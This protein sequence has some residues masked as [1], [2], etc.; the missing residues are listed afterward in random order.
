[1]RFEEF[2]SIVRQTVK[3][4]P[5]EFKS[6]LDNVDIVIEIWP[7]YA[8]AKSVFAHPGS[9]LF[10]LYRGVPK[11]KRDNNYSGVLPDKIVIFAGPILRFSPTPEAA[12]K[13]IK[14]TVLH[15]FGHY[16]GMTE[17]EIRKAQR[18]HA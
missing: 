16:F 8:D 4:L 18:E 14:K 17:Q 5:E 11:T 1:M 15:E 2:E 13:Q 6:A 10:G 3:S 12:R 9:I 7:T